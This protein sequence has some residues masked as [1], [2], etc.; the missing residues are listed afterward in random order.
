MPP[1]SGILDNVSDLPYVDSERNPL[2]PF[3]DRYSSALNT[4]RYPREITPSSPVFTAETNYAFSLSGDFSDTQGDSQATSSPARS[5]PAAMSCSASPSAAPLA[6]YTEVSSHRLDL[7][8]LQQI[9][10]LLPY[11]VFFFSI[12][13]CIRS[14]CPI[15]LQFQVCRMTTTISLVQLVIPTLLNS[16]LPKPTESP[17]D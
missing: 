15:L 6:E 13:D 14:I 1:K 16:S 2:L 12:P 7:S 10:F 11:I 9:S 4:N 5:P 3:P 17:L 8:L